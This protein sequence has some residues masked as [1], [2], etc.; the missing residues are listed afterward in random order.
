MV[1][2]PFNPANLDE[3]ARFVRG[4][5][6]ALVRDDASADDLAAQTLADA[7]A[8]RP[9]TGAGFRG[10]L[11]RVVERRFRRTLRD[12]ERRIRRERAAS[13][14]EAQP[15][16]VDLAAQVELTRRVATA[17]AALDEPYRGTLFRRYFRDETPTEIA[18]GEN[19]PVATVKTR[20][21]RG[22][23]RLRRELDALHSGDREQ[24]RAPALLL[25]STKEVLLMSVK[26]KVVAA[27]AVILIGGLTTWIAGEK[28][29][30]EP[31]KSPVGRGE[32]AT[33]ASAT[34]REKAPADEKAARANAT[35][36]TISPEP[37]A[38]PFASGVVVDESGAPLA[39]VAVVANALDRQEPERLGR[40]TLCFDR[41]VAA[42]LATSDAA[43]RY[44]VREPS[45]DLV[46]LLFVKSGFT[47]GEWRELSSEREENQEHRVVLARGRRLAGTVR[48]GDGRPIARALLGAFSHFS[49]TTEGA[50]ATAVA[51]HLPGSPSYRLHG[52]WIEQD[53]FS[54]ADGKYEFTTLPTDSFRGIVA[55]FGYEPRWLGDGEWFAAPDLVFVRNSLLIDVVDRATKLPVDR[56]IASV[57]APATRELIC[58]RVSLIAASYPARER[59]EIVPGRLYV[60]PAL[61]G[62]ARAL[63]K[64]EKCVGSGPRRVLVMVSAPG[65]RSAEIECDL[66]KEGEPPHRTIELEPGADEPSLAGRIAGADAATIDVYPS[67]RS[68]PRYCDGALVHVDVGSRGDFAIG[69]L[70]AAK[71]KLRVAA[72]GCAPLMLQVDA[73]DRSL[74]IDLL[75]A[76]SLDVH[77]SRRN[78]DPAP[79]FCVRVET[80]E[81]Y[82]HAWQASTD[83]NGDALLEG[84]ATG[85]LRYGV[86]D[87]EMRGE[88]NM[89]EA[90]AVGPDGYA[91][92]DVVTLAAGERKRLD[93]IAPE[94]APLT[95]RVTSDA[96]AALEGATLDVAIYGGTCLYMNGEFDRVRALHPLTDAGGVAT[97]DLFPGRYRVNATFQA[98]QQSAMVVVPAEGA[99]RCDITLPV[100]SRT[101]RLR[102]HVLDR[103]T[104]APLARIPVMVSALRDGKFVASVV[105]TT[106]AG[107][108]SFVLDHVPATELSIDAVG[109]ASEQGW[110]NPASRYSTGVVRLTLAPDEER[111]VDF[112]LPVVA[113]L[114]PD[115]AAVRFDLS[116]VDSATGRP[117]TD[118]AVSI[119]I[120][121][122]G[123]DYRVGSF[124]P[125]AEGRVQERVFAADKY[126]VEAIAARSPRSGDHPR[127]ERREY[128]QESR[129]VTPENGVVK[130]RIEIH[131]GP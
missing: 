21:Q 12:D 83:E 72:S 121:C 99:A 61:A 11:A 127:G 101:G 40:E 70:P 106:T 122:D 113:P 33:A 14:P 102:G 26:T 50:A 31:S 116:I 5:A 109:S 53:V 126:R 35:K 131:R 128:D 15:S 108:G 103:E 51:R 82:E 17:F 71:Y 69:G 124:S 120:E 67:D 1:P 118:A 90:P 115:A 7:V 45:L 8:Q 9:T 29:A 107:D 56:P 60:D 89:N 80:V 111:V 92:E 74:K 47:P 57:L 39:G 112:S 42:T 81:R 18:R 65:H 6:R 30:R 100:W 27:A 68:G 66:P 76:P 46:E 105:R 44:A 64:F 24:W 98:V 49:S 10:W 55:A 78:G 125:D 38:L 79:G 119:T 41:I 25:L 52:E 117:P 84:L 91:S 37:G 32:V 23:E 77:V 2:P 13:R 97:I 58:S 88:P 86:L 54:D 93:L 43:G 34:S 96:G 85:A 73:P 114:P 129:E 123:V 22:L 19:V 94:R 130:L 28:F 63:E 110:F 3:H 20:L 16:A 59:G 4:L 48:D 62:G 36:P 87:R 75:P 104:H 95:V